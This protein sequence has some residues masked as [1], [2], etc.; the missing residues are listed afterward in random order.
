M[1]EIFSPF[2]DCS[3]EEVKRCYPCPSVKPGSYVYVCDVC[4]HINIPLK[5]V[6]IAGRKI[7][8]QLPS[9]WENIEYNHGIR[10]WK[11]EERVYKD[12]FEKTLEEGKLYWYMCYWKSAKIHSN[13]YNIE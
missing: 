9:F 11:P 2:S 10:G 3:V 6:G 12:K 7:L 5:V 8:V 1:K 4:C 13:E